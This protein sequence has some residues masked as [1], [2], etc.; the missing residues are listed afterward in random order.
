MAGVIRR[1]EQ[2]RSDRAVGPYALSWMSVERSHSEPCHYLQSQYEV[3]G[4]CAVDVR[5]ANPL[6]GDP[7][8]LVSLFS[9][10]GDRATKDIPTLKAR[11]CAA[12]RERRPKD[13]SI[14]YLL[15]QEFL[16]RFAI[17]A[18]SSDEAGATDYQGKEIATRGRSVCAPRLLVCCNPFP[19]H[20]VKVAPM[21]RRDDPG[22][23]DSGASSVT[24][25]L[26]IGCEPTRSRL[27]RIRD[28][29]LGRSKA[30][31]QRCGARRVQEW[32]SATMRR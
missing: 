29:T 15:I 21:L 32:P 9:V 22:R 13:S 31:P 16:L 5:R 26:R 6:G 4:G 3:N 20:G 19:G 27:K 12:R 2:G 7:N 30:A 28:S 10:S 14:A 1:E 11:A 8:D 17:S 23:G 25:G 18:L 24:Q